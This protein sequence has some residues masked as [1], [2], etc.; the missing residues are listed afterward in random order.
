MVFLYQLMDEFI[1]YCAE[2]KDGRVTCFLVWFKH[3]ASKINNTCIGNKRVHS[4]SQSLEK[5]KLAKQQPWKT[6]VISVITAGC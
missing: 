1:L 5:C 3:V 2:S 6:K 4:Q